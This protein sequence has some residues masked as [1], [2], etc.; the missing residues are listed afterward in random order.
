[1]AN[2]YSIEFNPFQRAGQMRA[3]Q[4]AA[5]AQEAELEMQPLRKE[6]AQ[7]ENEA[8]KRSLQPK[9]DPLED[10]AND[11]TDAFMIISEKDPERRRQAILSIAD[12][13]GSDQ[14]M[15]AVTDLLAMTPEE[16][17]AALAPVI[18]AAE[19]RG[20]WKTPESIDSQELPMDVREYEYFKNLA[21]DQQEE[22]LRVKRGVDPTFEEKL[23]QTQELEKAKIISQSEAKAQI[24][25]PQR[26]R[27]AMGEISN[28]RRELAQMKTLKERAAGDTT[29]FA[30]VALG[31]IPFTEAGGYRKNID[32]LKAKIGF[33]TLQEMRNNSPTGGALGQVSEREL[34][35]LQAA[36]SNIDPEQKEE[37]L[38]KNLEEVMYR[39]ERSLALIES[40]YAEDSEFFGMSEQQITKAL[41]EKYPIDGK[42]KEPEQPEG[43][44]WIG[45]FQVKVKGQ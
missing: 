3:G 15:K 22:Y 13:Q 33:D 27:A 4:L 19:A 32:S 11:A 35:F 38:K 7:L 45:R 1:M 20:Q 6:R 26:R 42:P 8:L 14:E 30:Q 29:G 41:N 23:R 16:Q 34:D 24:E 10:L 43:T 37:Q 9:V 12:K 36:I 40:E 44:Q 2:R 21:P 5:Q 39:W 31:W 18:Q 25:A 17:D 28:R